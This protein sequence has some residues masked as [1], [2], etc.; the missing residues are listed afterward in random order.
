MFNFP[1]MRGDMAAK[2]RQ[3]AGAPDVY[4]T[5][6]DSVTQHALTDAESNRR[7]RK[8][9]V[10]NNYY[11]IACE[12]ILVPKPN[13]KMYEMSSSLQNVDFKLASV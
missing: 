1:S 5:P 7:N 10:C 13:P 2:T 6:R 8:C 4:I 3:E 12:F 11:F 9:K